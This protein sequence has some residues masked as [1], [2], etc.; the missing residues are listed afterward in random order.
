MALLATLLIPVTLNYAGA[1][2][3]IDLAGDGGCGYA[4][5]HANI[6]NDTLFF[7]CLD[8]AGGKWVASY[9]STRLTRGLL[10]LLPAMAM[11]LPA[12]AFV[13]DHGTPVPTESRALARRSQ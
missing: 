4:G 11:A 6:A 8:G 10:V 1:G 9:D 13:F 7:S 2:E 5:R 12:K 3:L